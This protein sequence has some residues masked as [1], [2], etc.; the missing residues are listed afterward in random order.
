M[1][2]TYVK[3]RPDVTLDQRFRIPPHPTSADAPYLTDNHVGVAIV[4]GLIGLIGVA[5]GLVRLVRA[6]SWLPLFVA[7]SA[8]MI[9]IPE[10]FYDVIG[11]VYFPLSPI[12]PLG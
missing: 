5:L 12:E 11:A 10:V 4:M 2:I 7:L 6:G 8:S 1:A 3:D 9:C